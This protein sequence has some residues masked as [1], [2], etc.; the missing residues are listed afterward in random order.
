MKYS[1]KQWDTQPNKT[2]NKCK[3]HN[4]CYAASK[5]ISMP[6]S[7]Q[8]SPL[9]FSFSGLMISVPI[10]EFD[11]LHFFVLRFG[12]SSTSNDMLATYWKEKIGQNLQ[13]TI[14]E[15]E[16]S[17]PKAQCLIL[18]MQTFQ[19]MQGQTVSRIS[20]NIKLILSMNR[21]NIWK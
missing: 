12:N 16:N 1:S 19:P 8:G 10:D 17:L 9:K 5:S 11:N 14:C 4:R 6:Q 18:A 21:S 13:S 2:L 15:R 3:V 20:Q 7:L